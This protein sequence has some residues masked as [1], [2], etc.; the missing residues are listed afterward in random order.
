MNSGE[1]SNFD[2]WAEENYNDEF[3]LGFRI[4]EVLYRA[5]S[6]FQHIDIVD[7]VGYGK[8]LFNDNRV[9]LSERDEFIYH[10][11]ISHVPLFLH[12]KPE[13]VLVI[14]GGDG[15][16]VRE[17]I[18]HRSVAYCRLVEIDGKVV[19]GCREHIPQTAA[20]LDEDRVEVSIEDGVRYVANATEKYDVVII[21]STDPIGP[22]TPLF[23]PEFYGNVARLLK[24]GGLVVS[25][26]ENP[27]LEK[28]GQF[29]LV[30]TVRSVFPCVAVYNY[31]NM[32]YPGGLWS[33]SLA[34]PVKIDPVLDLDQAKVQASGL[35][36][37]YYSPEV[38]RAAF[39]LPAFQQE[40]LEKALAPP[41]APGRDETAG[42]G[43]VAI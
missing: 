1:K 27:Y 3:R 40:M 26:A 6:D 19:E 30:R 28:E 32:T 14:G 4:K 16:T 11:M 37:K 9:M 13:R 22:A 43:A 34:S 8:M 21:D 24:E 31:T 2:L 15:G 35:S 33:F 41:E 10:E 25:Q 5:D 18:R 38:H 36:F 20:A 23:G 17:V 7:T 29:A 42:G 39:A 12:P